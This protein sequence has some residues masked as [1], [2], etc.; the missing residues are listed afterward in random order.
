VREEEKRE[1]SVRYRRIPF[2]WEQNRES[3]AVKP[4]C[5][6]FIERREQ[7]CQQGALYEAAFLRNVLEPDRASEEAFPKWNRSPFWRLPAQGR[8]AG[9]SRAFDHKHGGSGRPISATP[10]PDTA[11]P[12]L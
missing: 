11:L 10:G 7:R 6:R 12:Q 5:F 8:S 4:N 3:V 1:G 9:R 2:K